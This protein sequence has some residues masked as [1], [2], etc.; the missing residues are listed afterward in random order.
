MAMTDQQLK[1]AF[2]L[3]SDFERQALDPSLFKWQ[4]FIEKVGVSKQTLWRNGKF[5]SEFGRVQKLTKS[6]KNEGKE[7]TVKGSKISVL[8]SEIEKLKK[9]IKE[10]QDERDK[11]REALAYAAMI[12]R[13]RKIDPEEF[14][15]RSPLLNANIKVKDDNVLDLND[16]LIAQFRKK[17]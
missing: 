17:K 1:L 8:E 3:L 10:L 2:K 4:F 12:A 15:E 9:Q 7:Y 14:T 11:A 5:Y 16:P 13:R 6:Y